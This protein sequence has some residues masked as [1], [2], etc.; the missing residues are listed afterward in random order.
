MLT[1]TSQVVFEL[2]ENN[3]LIITCV[4]SAL[5]S[6]VVSIITTTITAI[7]QHRNEVKRWILEK[8]ASFYLD[9]YS[10]VEII[11]KK[12]KLV[13]DNDF[14]NM[15]VLVKPKIKL[16]ASK[17]T[18]KAFENFY[19]YILTK[20][21]EFRYFYRS[22]DP[23]N[24]IEY[25][26]DDDGNEQISNPPCEEDYEDFSIKL[27]AYKKENTPDLNEI[28]NHIEA[29]YQSMRTDLGSNMK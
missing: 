8:R 27:D 26:F 21:R 5:L 3:V 17:K 4:L 2:N 28:K 7:K 10:D 9:F 22:N 12:R 1:E 24:S 19:E 29:L 23:S 16:L 18:F 11:M 15:L 25:Y 14:Y 6:I 13:Y 20:R